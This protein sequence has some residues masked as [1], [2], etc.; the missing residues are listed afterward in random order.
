[1][2]CPRRVRRTGFT[3]I[4]LLVVM[5]IISI[6]IGLLLPAVQKIR[7]AANRMKCSN[8]M[9]QIGLAV[10]NF[11]LTYG[12]LPPAWTPDSGAGTFNSNYGNGPNGTPPPVYGTIHF[13]LLPFIEQDNLYQLSV[14]SVSFGGTNYNQYYSGQGSPTNVPATIL[15]MYLCPSD[16]TLN[17]NLQRYG[18]ASTSYAANMMIFDPHG[19]GNVVQGM[20]NGTSNTVIF[21]ERYKVCQPTVPAGSYT[22]PAWAMHPAIVSHGWDSPVFGWHDMGGGYDP[23]I[24]GGVGYAFQVRPAP[25]N[26]VY[27]VTQ[28]S[29]T[30]VMNV[31]MGDGSVRGVGGSVSLG[32]WIQACNPTQRGTLGSDW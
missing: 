20:P 24:D 25:Q 12:K 13:M 3:L 29:H 23:S 7:E 11:E 27:P 26:C 22:G 18:Y 19:P 10:H 21:A 2:S 14:R 31:A 8:N 32:T 28:G 4:E 15:Q 17:S 9:K 6:L 5:S 16:P 1:M 30:G